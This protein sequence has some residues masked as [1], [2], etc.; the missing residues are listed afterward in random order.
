MEREER[1]A[2]QADVKKGRTLSGRMAKAIKNNPLLTP[3]KAIV[4]VARQSIAAEKIRAYFD[5]FPRVE[6]YMKQIPDECR[7]NMKWAEAVGQE[8]RL[9][10][11]RPRDRAGNYIEDGLEY[12][13]DMEEW[14]SGQPRLLTRTGHEK[15]FG[16]I[17][18]LCGR[19]RRLEDIN[20]SNYRFKSEAE[21]QAVNTTIQGSAADIT[22]GAM[23]RI[24]RSKRLN[25]LGAQLL[26]QVHDEL[27]LQVPE[28]NAEEALPIIKECMEHPF[29]AG[30]D[31]LL[32]A[33][34]ADA[35]I[36]NSWAEK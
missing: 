4:L 26:N 7:D 36:V 22:K 32:V 20:H 17:R 33:I 18:T 13:W 31:P 19:Y 35:K 3:E 9:P 12:D 2:T 5:T 14:I 30:K 8:E 23:L 15:K 10:R 1:M 27:I 25:L 34:P 28:E 29:A 21:R 6:Q 16:F 24:E 11:D